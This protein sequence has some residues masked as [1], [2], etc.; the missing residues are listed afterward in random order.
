[1]MNIILGSIYLI[2][3]VLWCVYVIYSNG[4]NGGKKYFSLPELIWVSLV[5][6]LFWPLSVLL[7]V[8]IRLFYGG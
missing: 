3:G 4:I 5:Q 1:M 2:I 6:I 7:A 8:I